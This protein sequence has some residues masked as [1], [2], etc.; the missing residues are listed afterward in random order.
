MAEPLEAMGRYP[1]SRVGEVKGVPTVRSF[2][3]MDKMGP[4]K[5]IKSNL[6]KA[7][8]SMNTYPVQF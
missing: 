5:A 6:L 1:W 2:L 4:A 8:N 3:V 7:L